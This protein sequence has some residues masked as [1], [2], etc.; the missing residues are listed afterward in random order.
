VIVVVGSAALRVDPAGTGVAVGLA[1]EI[2]IAAAGASAVELVTKIGEDGAGEELLLA[3]ARGGVGH[4][5][6]LRDAAHPTALAVAPAGTPDDDDLA[7]ALLAELEAAMA[8]AAGAAASLPVGPALEPADVALGLRYLRDYRVL[9]IV[10]PL[11]DG[12]AGVAAEAASFADATL[13]VVARPGGTEP[14]ASAAATIV[15]APAE[16]PDGAF[17]RLV[18]RFAAAVDAGVPS[19][20]AFRA[21][22][23]AGGWEVAAG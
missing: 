19:A 1:A 5:A 11:A 17:A 3:L 7:P 16:D 15:E 22:V 14:P 4:L 2:A 8:P 12:A 9:V 13:V 20:E 23:A 6:V 18:G 21:T 10:E